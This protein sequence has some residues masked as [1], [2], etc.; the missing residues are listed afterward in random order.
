M[1][2]VLWELA[3]GML[4]AGMSTR[5]VARGLN[6]NFSTISHLQHRF[7][8]FGSASNWL[9]VFFCEIDRS[10]IADLHQVPCVSW[11]VASRCL[12]LH[13]ITLHYITLH[14]SHLADALIQSDLQIGAF[15]L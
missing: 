13:Y 15:T 14:L 7:R 12:K 10:Q 6:V 11:P 9:L 2:Y 1:P 8:E 3:N 5:A 4:T